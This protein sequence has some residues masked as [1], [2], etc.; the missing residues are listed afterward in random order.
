VSEL[1]AIPGMPVVR[2]KL[3][4][5][6]AVIVAAS[7]ACGAARLVADDVTLK[8]D[9]AKGGMGIP[10]VGFEFA[11]T[12]EGDLGRWTVVR[13]PTA[14]EG[15]AI[16]HVSTD[17]H[18]DRF[19]LAIYQPLST[20]NVE[21]SVRLKIIAG[22][23]QTA[24]VAVSLRNPDS[25]YAISANAFEH[26]VDLLLFSGG[27][28]RRIDSAE[29]EITRDRWHTLGVRINDDHFTISVDGKVL[30]TTFDRTR[31]KDGRIALWTQEDN[32]TRFAQIEIRPL[33]NTEWR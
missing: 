5:Y 33:P 18:E 12:G 14:V 7:I 19:P 20:E 31:M 28:S 10:P 23:S 3:T 24:G 4:K 16:E 2:Q 13:D 25:Y 8:I 29:A 6:G 9:F 17:Q 21:L 27:K 22:V 30:L 1:A 32:A 15:I 26:R 11:R